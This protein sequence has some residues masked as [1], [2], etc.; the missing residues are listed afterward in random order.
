MTQLML[1]ACTNPVWGDITHTQILCQVT[2]KEFGGPF[3]FNVMASDPEPHGRQLWKDL[4]GGKY[5]SIGDYVAGP[6]KSAPK[7]VGT[8]K[9]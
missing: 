1:T 5:G 6:P 8:Q 9:L 3:P 2:T 4:N 7:S